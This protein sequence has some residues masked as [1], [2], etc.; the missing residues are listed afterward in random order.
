M[1]S[2]FEYAPGSRVARDRRPSDRA[3]GCSSTASSS[4]PTDGHSVQDRQPRHR[5]GAGRGRR[6]RT[7]RRRPRRRRRAPRLR[8]RLGS[9]MPGARRGPSTCTASPGIIQERSRELA[10]LE[11]IDNG[12]PIKESRDVDRAA[13]RGA[14][15]LL[16]RLGRQ[17]R[18]RRLRRRPAAARRRRPGHPVELP[19][20]DA[21][22]EDRAGARLRQHRRAQAGRDHAAHRAAASPRS[23][24]RPTCRPA[25]STSSPAPARPGRAL[26]EHPDVDKVAFTGSTEVGKAIARVGRRHRQEG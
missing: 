20:A 9:R 24:S 21:G 22:V 14:L 18:V 10:V 17:A 23:A 15:L 6:G 26:V 12:K 8:R 7:E 11:T 5:G 19:A 2:T 3:T 16:R 1:T 4:T 25:W 13:R